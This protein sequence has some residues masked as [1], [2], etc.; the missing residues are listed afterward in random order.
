[1]SRLATTLR[2]AAARARKRRKS[3]RR[4][5]DFRY[6]L[7]CRSSGLLRT[8]NRR[9][10]GLEPAAISRMPDQILFRAKR[11]KSPSYRRPS[12]VSRRP[13]IARWPP[14]SCVSRLQNAFSLERLRG[15]RPQS[16]FNAALCRGRQSARLRWGRSPALKSRLQ[17]WLSRPQS[18]YPDGCPRARRSLKK[19]AE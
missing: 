4:A 1:M 13:I 9:R 8:W 10:F 11:R 2:K 19:K 3:E 15:A 6:G 5:G 16:S 7:S 12:S 14:W 17:V 18:P